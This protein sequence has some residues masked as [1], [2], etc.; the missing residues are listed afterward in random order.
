MHMLFIDE[1]GSPPPPE[2]SL[3]SPYFV[4]GGVVVPEEVWGKLA[5]ELRRIKLRFEVAGE[6]KWRHFAPARDGRKP[7]ALSHLDPE[8]KE[9]LRSSLYGAITRYRSI[10]VLGVVAH[11]PFAY[12]SGKV[13]TADDLYWACYRR[14]TERFHFYLEDLGRTVG[15]RRKGI[16]VCDHRAPKDDERLRELHHRMLSGD[17]GTATNFRNLIEGLFIA[18][19][20][21]SVGIQFADMVAGAIF[22]AFSAR[23]DRF[24]DQIKVSFRQAPDGGIDGYGLVRFP[25]GRWPDA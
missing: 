19:S 9:A 13:E 3:A 11:V 16:V 25:G 24:L 21:F 15:E 2:R 1:S 4:L 18:P 8:R 17:P 10:R 20:H 22:R 12:E 23:D 6:I 7:N 5:D 14:M